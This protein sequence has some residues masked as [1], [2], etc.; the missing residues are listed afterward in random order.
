MIPGSVYSTS[1]TI[2]RI[3]GYTFIYL[4]LLFF[5]I[6][7]FNSSKPTPTE[8]FVV[9][10]ILFL[11]FIGSF[12]LGI[13]LNVR[14]GI[15][16]I[17]IYNVILSLGMYYFFL[18]YTESPYGYNPVDAITY[19]N[20]ASAL[21]DI[22]SLSGAVAYLQSQDAEISDYGFPL[23]LRLVFRY[24]SSD[25]QARILL[26]LLNSLSFAL[27]SI[28]T[29]KLGRFFLQSK[30]A[31]VAMLLWGLNSCA[32]WSN[33]CGMKESV[34]ITLI[35]AA[36]YYMYC[37]FY[38]KN[39][40]YLI[41]TFAFILSTLFF[42]HYIT[43]FL[44]I[45]LFCHPVYKRLSSKLL[46]LLV[47]G[48]WVLATFTSYLISTEYPL[49]AIII[50]KQAENPEGGGGSL[51]RIIMNSFAGFVG[52]YPN[53]LLSNTKEA[54]LYNPYSL[55]KTLISLFGLY[56]MFYVIKNRITALYPITFFIF[57]NIIL[58]IITVFSFDYRFSYTMIPLFFILSVYGYQKLREYKYRKLLSFVYTASMLI[59]IL[60]Y[61]IR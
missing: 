11:F 45:L 22:P 40:K 24:T 54:L 51:F 58:V 59:L 44:L 10:F 34:F 57:L 43:L 55:L 56:G 49:L 23:L 26:I 30:E 53:F 12:T 3:I 42:R 9:P 47:A 14:S 36:M 8:L 61:N 17:F 52:P 29:Y 32:I 37:W 16:V 6:I 27:C 7:F 5:F 50:H 25:N 33:S 35:T 4:L 38:R 21:K 19:Y 18:H 60:F 48:V 20:Y 2:N 15:V 31:K 1:N 28:F 39:F 13:I 46:F 41:L